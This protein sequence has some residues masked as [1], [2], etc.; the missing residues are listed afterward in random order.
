MSTERIMER[1][2][3]SGNYPKIPPFHLFQQTPL[4]VLKITLRHLSVS[5][6]NFH[7]QLRNHHH[8]HHYYYYGWKEKGGFQKQDGRTVLA[9]LDKRLGHQFELIIVQI[10]IIGFIGLY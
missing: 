2:T 1:T 9:G 3:E 5:L 6:T 4:I 7:P 8:H 10:K